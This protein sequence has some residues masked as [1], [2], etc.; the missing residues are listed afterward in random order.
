MKKEIT[1]ISYSTSYMLTPPIAFPMFSLEQQLDVIDALVE[2]M[3]T[4]PEV[5]KIL[6]GIVK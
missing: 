3:L 6:Q 2:S 5:E 4:F 1:G